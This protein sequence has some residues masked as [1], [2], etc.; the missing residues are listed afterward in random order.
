MGQGLNRIIHAMAQAAPDEKVFMAKWDIKDGFWR[1]DCQQDEEWNFAYVLPQKE[2]MPV[3]LVVPEPPSKWDGLNHPPTFVQHLKRVEMWQNN[4]QRR[5]LAHWKITS[6]LLTHSMARITSRSKA[7][8]AC[9]A[10]G[11]QSRCMWMTTY[12]W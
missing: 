2:G 7:T 6:S 1:L 9:K 12:R 10:Y 8:K 5:Q 3:K 4:T 11:M